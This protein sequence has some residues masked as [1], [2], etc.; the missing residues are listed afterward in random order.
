MSRVVTIILVIAIAVSAVGAAGCGS[1]TKTISQTGANGQVTT[2]T[3]PNIHF[4]KTKFVIHM[5]LAFGAFHRYIYKPLKAGAFKSGA[6]HRLKTLLKAGAAALFAAHELKLAHEDA[7]SDS[8]LRPLAEKIDALF[9]KLGSLGS[10]LKGGS[11]NPADILNSAS[12][13]GAL[14]AAS[15]GIGVGIKDVVPALGG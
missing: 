13:V 1:S 12:A 4:A 8:H 9:S 3:V 6:P 7:L 5:G 2:K 15:G 10:A 14:G 11:L